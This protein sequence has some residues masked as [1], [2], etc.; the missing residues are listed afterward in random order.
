VLACA[1]PDDATFALRIRR[2]EASADRAASLFLQTISRFAAAERGVPDSDRSLLEIARVVRE[3]DS[4]Q[5]KGVVAALVA[6]E[7]DIGYLEPLRLRLRGVTTC[8]P[9]AREVDAKVALATPPG[10]L[11]VDVASGEVL[12]DGI[13]IRV[14]EGTRT[15][16]MLLAVTGRLIRR[17]ALMDLIWP[18]LEADAAVN[19]IKT[20]VH[21]ARIQLGD[22]NAIVVVKGSYALGEGVTTTYRQILELAAKTQSRR[23]TTADRPGLEAAYDR[24]AR[25]LV[26]EWATRTWFLPYA[27]ALKGAMRS[28]GEALIL[29]QI[30]AMEYDL[31]LQNARAMID[32]D[33][34]NEDARCL[35]MIVYMNVGNSRAALSEFEDFTALLKAGGERPSRKI[36]T[37][38]KHVEVGEDWERRRAVEAA[39][40]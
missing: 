1:D 8:G 6:K 35:L 32:I 20:C 21:R 11:C 2:A 16:L 19:A 38:V 15:L 7:A 25:G 26:G 14:S 37:L 23:M 13:P 10:S 34:F 28:I 4:A 17:D 22:S 40:P 31:A 30:D 27:R 33:A 36:L 12:R 9:W 24:L 3:S 18:D 29:D 5:L 39:L